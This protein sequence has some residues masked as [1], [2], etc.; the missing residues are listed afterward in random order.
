[1]HLGLPNKGISPLGIPSHVGRPHSISLN[2][3]SDVPFFNLVLISQI[4]E[5]IA[6]VSP[7]LLLRL[8]YCGAP[9]STT[10]HHKSSNRHHCS[11]LRFIVFSKNGLTTNTNL[12]SSKQLS[13]TSTEIFFLSESLE[14]PIRLRST[15]RSFLKKSSQQSRE[16]L[17]LD[18]QKCS[19]CADCSYIVWGPGLLA[20]PGFAPSLKSV[21]SIQPFTSRALP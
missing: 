20:M 15:L 19:I 21:S 1:M 9:I 10:V 4:A 5:I 3:K 11:C 16:I 8:S 18:L 6:G 14:I 13:L 12:S 2:H 7:L 17:E